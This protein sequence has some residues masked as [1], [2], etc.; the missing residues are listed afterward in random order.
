MARN[1]VI[2][3]VGENTLVAYPWIGNYSSIGI[4]LADRQC[5]DRHKAGRPRA[6]TPPSRSV[7]VRR[8][9]VSSEAAFDVKEKN[10]TRGVH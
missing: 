7:I 10:A 8:A 5:H 6:F 3:K 1:V 9:A 2:A 4:E